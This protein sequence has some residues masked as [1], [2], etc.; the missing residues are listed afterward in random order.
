MAEIF[1]RLVIRILLA[2][3][4]CIMIY[5]YRYAHVIFYPSVKRQVLRRIKPAENA[6][7]TLHLCSRIM[8]IAIIFSSI[9]FNETSGFFLSLFHFS[10]WGTIAII[11]YLLS[12]YLF[13]SIVFYNFDYTDEILKRKNMSYA[14]ISFCH[15]LVI[16]YLTRT[17][18]IESE[19][20]L[21]ILIVLWLYMLVIIGFS[22][23]YYT[24]ISKL[25]FNRL[26][27]QKNLSLCFSYGGFIC[28]TG[29]IIASCFDQEHYDL[30]IYCIQVLL[31]T[32]LALIV[33]PIFKKGL[34]KI[35]PIKI[36]EDKASEGQIDNEM[37]S[38]GYGFF[39]GSVFIAG[40]ILTTMIVNKIQF[41]T[42]Y[43]F[44]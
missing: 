41:G 43:P 30:T 36:G 4:V 25:S 31:K 16:A 26:L 12:L 23:K 28:G 32:I 22:V 34:F 18:M 42:I 7:D 15:A 8:G 37:Q 13:E 38:L 33:F 11:L 14:M 1:D 6:P 39:E 2:G 21:V 19:N 20:S 40:A 10:V 27:I 3:F 9:S 44:F 35:F 24:L 17:V 29:F 5:F